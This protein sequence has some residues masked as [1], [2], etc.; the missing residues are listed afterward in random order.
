MVFNR[1]D[2]RKWRGLESAGRGW[3]P[4]GRAKE[5]SRRA[6]EPVGRPAGTEKKVSL[7]VVALYMYR[8]I[9]P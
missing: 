7:Y 5:P 4:A 3:E 8:S 6:K 2:V 9:G 1:G